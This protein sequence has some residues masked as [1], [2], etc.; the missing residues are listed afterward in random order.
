MMTGEIRLVKS[1]KGIQPLVE[2]ICKIT[3]SQIVKDYNM[4]YTLYYAYAIE[5]SD[6]K[7]I[8]RKLRYSLF[9]HCEMKPLKKKHL[10]S[11]RKESRSGYRFLH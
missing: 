3:Q 10:V 9:E 8:A 7:K 2:E 5:S 11:K 6:R 1:I 4:K